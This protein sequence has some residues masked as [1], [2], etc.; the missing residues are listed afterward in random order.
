VGERHQHADGK[1]WGTF[2]ATGY[3][4]AWAH[5]GASEEASVIF[6]RD[7]HGRGSGHVAGISFAPDGGSIFAW[8]R[9]YETEVSEPAGGEGRPITRFVAATVVAQRWDFAGRVLMTFTHRVA[10]PKKPETLPDDPRVLA[11]TP[12]VRHLLTGTSDGNVQGWKLP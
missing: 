1:H 4:N 9:L 12:D 5:G 7:I 10:F 3:V 6:A 8:G 2:G 11:I